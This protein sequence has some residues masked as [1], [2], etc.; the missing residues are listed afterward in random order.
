[1]TDE[2]KDVFEIKKESVKQFLIIVGGSFLGCFIAILLAG[3]ILKPKAPPCM[4]HRMFPP[5]HAYMMKK[6][7]KYNHMQFKHHEKNRI[8]KI[9]NKTEL[10]TIDN[11]NDA[12]T[13]K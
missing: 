10:K 9:T 11:T 5:H 6:P 8:S 12:K 1:M 13:V 7:P 4:A 2:K 3:Q